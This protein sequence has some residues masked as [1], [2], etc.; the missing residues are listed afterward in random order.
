MG[1]KLTQIEFINRCKKEHPEYTYDKTCYVNARTDVIVTCPIHGDFITTPN[2]FIMGAKGGC[3][4]CSTPALK[5]PLSQETFIIR[6]KQYFPNYD[7][8]KVIYTNQYNKVTVTCDKHNYT[9][10]PIAKD[11]M[12]GHGCPLC[13]KEA[14]IQKQILG[15]QEFIQRAS[16]IHNNKYDYSKVQYVNNRTKVEIICPEHGSFYQ[17]PDKHIGK[18]QQGCPKCKNQSSKGELTIQN[19]LINN[20]IN[21]IQQ[22]PIEYLDNKTKITKID[23]YLPD[24]NYFIEYNGEQH[25]VPVEYFGGTLKFEKQQRRDS[26]VRNY[27]NKTNIKL[28][29]ISYKENIINILKNELGID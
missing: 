7:Y 5:E 10:T 9:W 24:Y 11:L 20:N 28:I 12:R 22:Y 17:I 3:P 6:C 19:F 18:A 25:Y 23:F 4:K 29:E 13:G 2:R 14:G 26:Y 8:S 15:L 21:F 27:C 1:K 16:L